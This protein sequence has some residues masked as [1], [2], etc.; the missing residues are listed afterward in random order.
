MDA[1]LVT[2]WTDLCQQLAPAFTARTYVTFLHVVTAWALCRSRPAVTG[3]VLTIGQRLL[4]HPAGHWVTYERFFYR[5]A[6]SLDDVSRLLLVRVVMPLVDEWGARDGGGGPPPVGL[7][8]D[9]TTA[10][11]Y[12]RHVAWAGYFKDASASNVP[13]TVCHWAHNW[14]IGCVT[15]R[16]R[17]W[18]DW[19]IPLPVWFDLYRKRADCDPTGEKDEARPF[20][21]RHEIA[22]AMLE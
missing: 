7:N 19:V 18:P 21:S 2:A 3:L 14:V 1:E 10:A 6:W 13:R 11:R 9:D 16:C 22:A 20:R 17:R 15:F 8:V 4:G 12:G 5:A